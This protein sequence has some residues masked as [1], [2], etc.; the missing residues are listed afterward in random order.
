MRRQGSEQDQGGEGGKAETMEHGL[1]LVDHEMRAQK[2]W[3]ESMLRVRD[4]Y[5]KTKAEAHSPAVFSRP[6]TKTPA[7][8]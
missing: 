1:H 6:E 8:T 5:G 2:I 4:F 7:C 3:P